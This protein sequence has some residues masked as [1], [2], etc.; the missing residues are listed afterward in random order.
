MGSPVSPREEAAPYLG[1]EIYRVSL[2]ASSGNLRQACRGRCG[3]ERAACAERHLS[4]VTVGGCG[5]PSEATSPV[6]WCPTR[7][8][9]SFSLCVLCPFPWHSTPGKMHAHCTPRLSYPKLGSP[10]CCALHVPAPL[11]LFPPASSDIM[12]RSGACDTAPSHVRAP[13]RLRPRHAYR[14]MHI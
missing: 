10:A 4:G 14:R 6:S 7:V 11:R 5:C 12:Q 8:S 1:G 2:L 3:L 9:L 13:P